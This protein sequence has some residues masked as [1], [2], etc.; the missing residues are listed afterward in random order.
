[1]EAK[2]VDILSLEAKDI[3]LANKYYNK[4][5]GVNIKYLSG[6]N[7]GEINTK[8]FI[9]TLDYSL[10]LI[11][12][13]EV[14]EKKYRNRKFSF[15]SNGHDYCYRIINVTYKYSLKLF[16][17]VKKNLYVKIGTNPN[18]IILND[19]IYMKN[20]EVLAI[21]IEKDVGN[22][23]NEESLGKYFYYNKGKYHAKNNI[24]TIMSTSQLR[25][26]TYK[27]GF[28]CN[29]IKFIRYKRSSGA[30]RVGKCLFIDEK[31]YPAMH[32]WELCGL[33][34]KNMQEIDLAAFEA[35]IALTL[36]SIIDTLEIY[37]ENILLI[38]DY[39]SV[40]TDNVMETLIVNGKLRTKENKVE[41]KNSIWDGQSLLD[42]SL[43]EEYSNKGM[44]LL[45]N[46]FFKSCCFNC[47]IQKWFKDNN[48]TEISQLNGKTR[49]TNVEDIKLITTPSSIK[50]LKFGTFEQW[51]DNLESLFGIVKYDK[52]THYFRGEMV[53]THYQLLNTLQMS[54]KEIETFLK[55][56]FDYL[57]LL[58]EDNEVF[59]Y[60]I[61]YCYQDLEEKPLVFKNDIVYKLMSINDKFYKTKIFDEFKRDLLKS[62]INKIRLGKV[63]VRGNYSTL[64]G[65]P[66]E[67]LK[68]SIG[69]FDGS[70]IL[71]VGEVSSKKFDYNKVIL[72]SRSPHVTACNVWLPYNV[73]LRDIDKYMNQTEEIVYINSINE[74]V[75]QTLEGADF[76]SDTVLL[77]DNEV[78]IKA[79]KRNKG[80]FLVSTNNTEAEK[81]KRYYSYIEKNDLDIKTAGNYI[82]EIINLSQ[83]LNTLMWD[84]LNKGKK[85]KDISNIYEDICQLN[86]MSNI[87][88]DKAKKEF[89]VDMKKEIKEIK[90]RHTQK[91]EQGRNIKPYFFKFVAQN[92]GY[93]DKERNNY[94]SNLTSMDFLEKEVNKY[95]KNRN[96]YKKEVLSF[97]EILENESYNI[98]NTSYNQVNNVINLIKEMKEKQ[99]IIMMNNN[100]S[101]D[102]KMKLY[103]ENKQDYINYIGKMKF[104]RDT[105]ITILKKLDNDEY[106]YLHKSIIKILFGYPN[107]SFFEIIKETQE[108][109]YS[110]KR[111]DN[112]G[113]IEIYHMR[114][115]K[116]KNH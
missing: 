100:L 30:A 18:D 71:K 95:Q 23:I 101:N 3:Y 11:K 91:D 45:R 88:I 35:Y 29:G 16:N 112:F 28:L 59:K 63:Y 26:Y 66:I 64:C 8:K 84:Y 80:N 22:P 46:R 79:A 98:H 86:T 5:N 109:M 102:E 61:K 14:Y 33:K 48:I 60:H 72:G 6:I 9:N 104:T 62:L 7:K 67:M 76:D 56:T 83:E 93:Y 70:S 39:E 103:K 116:C 69:V 20:N 114:F 52:K 15:E 55:P 74:N 34:I 21:E 111:D 25:E 94:K 1:M 40:F 31:L 110:L 42:I 27:N 85:I 38:D 43:F 53:Q 37:S 92:K 90:N 99:Q 58:K 106:K 105:M 36:S 96:K 77:T 57:N 10:E 19:C 73:Q 13:R 82:G 108:K 47:N 78:L 2:G 65:N 54:E 87:E 113:D 12:L 50:Y 75:L 41:I 107:T 51:L 49:A 115:K 4:E 89:V 32:K 24:P 44:L 97:Y 81:R 68:Q 17:K